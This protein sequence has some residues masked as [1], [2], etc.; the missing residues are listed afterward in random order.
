MRVPLLLGEDFQTAYDSKRILASSAHNVD[1]GFKICRAYMAQSFVWSKTA[2]RKCAHQL[3]NAPKDLPSVYAIEDIRIEAGTVRYVKVASA[4]QGC[5]D[6][7]VEKVVVGL[8]SADIMVAPF[9][10]INADNPILPMANP[11]T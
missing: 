2:C 10:W 6:W 5:K 7:L 11:G 8:E 9:T 1:L 4:F 3:K